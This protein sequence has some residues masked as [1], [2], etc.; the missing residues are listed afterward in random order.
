MKQILWLI[1]LV[2][3]FTVFGFLAGYS[4][5][6]HRGWIDRRCDVIDSGSLNEVDKPAEIDFK[7]AVEDSRCKATP[8]HI[9]TPE[10]RKRFE[11]SDHKIRNAEWIVMMREEHPNGGDRRC[12]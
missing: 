1:V 7:K 9:K 11:R 12:N 3:M 2:V 5:G 4:L 6:H 10:E 8:I